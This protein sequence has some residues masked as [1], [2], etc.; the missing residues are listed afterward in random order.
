MCCGWGRPCNECSSNELMQV[1]S[2]SYIS[3]RRDC[4]TVT[5]T[6]TVTTTTTVTMLTPLCLLRPQ[7]TTPRTSCEIQATSCAT[8][9]SMHTHTHPCEQNT[10]V[11]RESERER[12][13]ARGIR[14][15]HSLLY[16]TLFYCCAVLCCAVLCCAVLCS[17]VSQVR[18]PIRPTKRKSKEEK[19]QKTP[20]APPNSTGKD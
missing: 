10:H 13:S 3:A 12:G 19:K 4:I 6:V 1:F 14:F 7:Y 8:H 5:V 18:E 15:V 20:P 2:F 9:T 11:K 16:P 17:R